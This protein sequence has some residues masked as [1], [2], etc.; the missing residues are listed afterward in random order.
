[1]LMNYFL[2]FLPNIAE[3]VTEVIAVQWHPISLGNDM[4]M[5]NTDSEKHLSSVAFSMKRSTEVFLCVVPI[6]RLK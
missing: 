5:T 1:M 2:F 4:K 6:F 3:V